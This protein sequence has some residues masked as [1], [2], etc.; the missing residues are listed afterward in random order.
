MNQLSGIYHMPSLSQMVDFTIVKLE[1]HE[2]DEPFDTHGGERY[3]LLD[4]FCE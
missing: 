1:V 2:D 4:S 3:N